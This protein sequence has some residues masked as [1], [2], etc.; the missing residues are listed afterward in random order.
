[1]LLHVDGVLLLIRPTC[2]SEPAPVG[3]LSQDRHFS[4]RTKLRVVP[5][6]ASSSVTADS[7]E[8]TRSS[9]NLCDIIS[10]ALSLSLTL[11]LFFLF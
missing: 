6:S 1:M 7:Q 10:I 11:I 8:D 9:Q 5:K 2:D 4:D 3:G